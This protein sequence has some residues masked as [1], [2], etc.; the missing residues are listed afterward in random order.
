MRSGCRSR[1]PLTRGVSDI[2]RARG[3]AR[4]QHATFFVLWTLGEQIRRSLAEP[5]RRGGVNDETSR[6]IH[7]LD[8]RGDRRRRGCPRSPTRGEPLVPMF[9]GAIVPLDSLASWTRGA[10]AERGATRTATAWRTS[11][12]RSERSPRSRSRSPRVAGRWAPPITLLEVPQDRD[13]LDLRF[14]DLTRD[15]ID[16]LV[17]YLRDESN[18]AYVLGVKVGLGDGDV[19]RRAN[20]V[21]PTGFPDRRRQR[22]LARGPRGGRC[23]GGRT[24]R[25]RRRVQERRRFPR[26]TDRAGWARP[27]SLGR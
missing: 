22:L 18:D 12:S 21:H 13:F 9:P 20:G 25:C 19:R 4:V 3:P 7:D 27:A 2:R 1:K 10:P 6:R 8:G 15:G 14:A 24:P 17:Y 11:S 16:D 23:D 5:H 26:T